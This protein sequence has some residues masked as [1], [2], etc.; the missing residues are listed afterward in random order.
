MSLPLLT[1][2]EKPVR[3]TRRFQLRALTSAAHEALETQVGP[4]DSVAG[5]IL[6]LRGMH[7]F[8]AGAEAALQKVE[9]PD[10]LAD[11]RPVFI[12]GK[13]A[14]DLK[15]LGQKPA[16]AISLSMSNDIAD[17][18]GLAYVLE[19]SS[20]GA[21]LLWKRAQGLGFADTHGARHLVAQTASPEGWTHIIGLLNQSE[22]IDI[23][24]IADF[25]NAHFAAA[26]T[27]MTRA[28]NDL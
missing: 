28:A 15:D 14:E 20:L 22:D 24:R 12:A 5:Y 17:L 21:R 1:P 23:Q 2:V 13:M 10:V 19:G 27:A 11:W 9:A 18:L 4:L 16:P 3:P 26:Q 7:A 6:Y 8:R 25:A